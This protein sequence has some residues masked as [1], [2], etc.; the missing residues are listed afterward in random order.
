MD[1]GEIKSHEEFTMPLFL[2]DAKVTEMIYNASPAFASEMNARKQVSGSADYYL[3]D[4]APAV[5]GEQVIGRIAML[6]RHVALAEPGAIVRLAEVEHGH[7]DPRFRNSLLSYLRLSSQ[8]P[9]LARILV[10]LSQGLFAWIE[11]DSETA[12]SLGLSAKEDDAGQFIFLACKRQKP[13]L[14]PL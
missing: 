5:L 11:E 10:G 13:A 4:E 9:N 14:P 7:F 3:E 8:E 1:L 2:P 6:S 12:N